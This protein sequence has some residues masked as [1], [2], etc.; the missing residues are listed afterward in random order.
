MTFCSLKSEID[1]KRQ[2]EQIFLSITLLI[3]RAWLIQRVLSSHNSALS[4]LELCERTHNYTFLTFHL[5]TLRATHLELSTPAV[6]LWW[7]AGAQEKEAEEPG[8]VV[9]DA[10]LDVLQGLVGGAEGRRGNLKWGLVLKPA[11]VRYFI[12]NELWLSRENCND[13]ALGPGEVT[14]DD[15]ARDLLDYRKPVDIQTFHPARIKLVCFK[16]AALL[17]KL[18]LF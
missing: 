18:Q 10:P 9:Q 7:V 2:F 5:A 1:V 16:K 17:S 3:C 11:W 8:E 6:L 15:P 13:G 4:Y 12:W 14:G